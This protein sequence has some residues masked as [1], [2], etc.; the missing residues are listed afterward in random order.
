ME[1]GFDNLYSKIYYGYKSIVF[2]NRV[3]LE[4]S[5]VWDQEGRNDR[6]LY[7]T[8]YVEELG[9]VTVKLVSV[10]RNTNVQFAFGGYC[11]S[12]E[13]KQFWGGNFNYVLV[14]TPAPTAV[15]TPAP[16]LDPTQTPTPAPTPTPTYAP[17]NSPI[18][19]PT[20]HPTS[21]PSDAPTSN[22][23]ATPTSSPVKDP[24]ATPTSVPSSHTTAYPTKSKKEKTPCPTSQP[25]IYMNSF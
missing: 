2:D 3:D 25:K 22:P 20:I 1:A 14:P 24:S 9:K 19:G 16:T 6:R 4:L 23:S 21:N 7:M 13:V 11:N 17:T 10:F 15:P 18:N 5:M 8:L 12:Y